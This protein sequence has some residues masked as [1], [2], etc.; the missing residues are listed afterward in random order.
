MFAFLR[1]R[2][3]EEEGTSFLGNWQD[4]TKRQ[5]RLLA[6]RRRE[7]AESPM[8]HRALSGKRV[9]ILNR[10]GNSGGHLVCLRS[11]SCFL[12]RRKVW[13]PCLGG[14][15]D[16]DSLEQLT[17]QDYSRQAHREW[18]LRPRV[19]QAQNC[20]DT[21]GSFQFS[22]SPTTWR[23]GR[24]SPKTRHSLRPICAN[25]DGA[26]TPPLRLRQVSLWR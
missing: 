3:P 7:G 10:P 24:T 11:D 15:D 16:A 23:C 18:P 19:G 8:P 22:H 9:E 13:G 25:M 1:L 20:G 26:N 14:W 5:S 2:M 4:S 17:S 21:A 12:Q 6:S